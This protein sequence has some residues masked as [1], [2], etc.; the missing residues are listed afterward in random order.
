MTLSRDEPAASRMARMLSRVR[1]VCDAMSPW[2]VAPVA[3]SMGPCPAR[4]SRSP[5]TIACEYGPMGAG[6][7][8][9]V[10]AFLIVSLLECAHCSGVMAAMLPGKAAGACIVL[11][12][13]LLQPA[14]EH[15]LVIDGG[16]VMDPESG[17]DAV[18]SVGISGGRI[19]AVSAGPLRGRAAI[20]ARGLVVAPGFIDLH[21]HGQDDENYA[22]RA[23]DGV[24][25]A[26]ELE[27]GTA[28]L[29]R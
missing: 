20:D 6:A 3:G 13:L 2:S 18:R 10:T 19:A 21:A 15:D 29:D 7:L 9:V 14:V 16:R 28:D 24:T 22:L 26:L 23:A 4:K 25:T 17:L 1:W 8:S 5:S 12:W 11:S 27:I